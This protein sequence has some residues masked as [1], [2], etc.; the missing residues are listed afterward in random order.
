MTEEDE[1]ALKSES[2]SVG[3]A[4][5]LKNEDVESEKLSFCGSKVDFIGSSSAV[6]DLFSVPYS[7][8]VG[9]SI[10]VHKIGDGTI[11]VDRGVGMDNWEE[12]RG[13]QKRGRSRSGPLAGV[14][15]ER[16]PAVEVSSELAVQNNTPALS[17]LA[18]ILRQVVARGEEKKEKEAKIHPPEHYSSSMMIPPQ[19]PRQ[20]INFRFHDMR[21]LVASDALIYRSPRQK[22]TSFVQ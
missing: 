4:S 5:L 17:F 9:V 2:N 12:Y 10:A 11:L 8:D 18:S 7:R 13:G 16:T 20:W 15:E 22:A 19:E 3:L 21:L 6:K 14:V 1:R